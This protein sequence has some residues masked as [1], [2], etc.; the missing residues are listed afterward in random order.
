MNES[1]HEVPLPGGTPAASVKPRENLIKV[2][3]FVE[4]GCCQKTN[5]KTKAELNGEEGISPSCGIFSAATVFFPELIIE[6]KYGD[7]CSLL[8]ESGILSAARPN[9]QK[10]AELDIE[11]LHLLR[12]G[13]GINPAL[14]IGPGI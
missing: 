12:P 10:S 6:M 3:L 5:S 9:V 14:C 4:V 7:G 1:A 11:L 8:G 2:C 13:L